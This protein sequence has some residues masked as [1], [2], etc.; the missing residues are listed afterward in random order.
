MQTARHSQID[1]ACQLEAMRKH[2]RVPAVRET[3]RLTGGTLT[4][5]GR[6]SWGPHQAELFLMGQ[7]AFGTDANEA[8]RNWIAC[9]LRKA[10]AEQFEQ[11]E[12]A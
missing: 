1:F 12:V 10:T 11:Q 8:I 2:D 9:V 7:S 3:C 6:T 4:M 5:P